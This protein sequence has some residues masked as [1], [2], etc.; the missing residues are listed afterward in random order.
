MDCGGIFVDHS[1]YRCCCAEERGESGIGNSLE[2]VFCRK[3]NEL[4]IQM[5]TVADMHW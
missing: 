2:Q 4:A 3:E 5:Q 1:A